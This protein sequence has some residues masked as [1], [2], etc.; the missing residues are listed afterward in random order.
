M[1]ITVNDPTSGFIN[2]CI[3]I[4]SSSAITLENLWISGTTNRGTYITDG[5][6]LTN[7]FRNGNGIG[8][9]GT[10]GTGGITVKYV[11]VRG[12]GRA[13]YTDSQG[14]YD[15]T[16]LLRYCTFAE[17]DGEF[18]IDDGVAVWSRAN[19]S[20]DTENHILIEKCIFANLPANGTAFGLGMRVDSF[21]NLDDLIRPILFSDGNLFWHC[22]VD[23][24]NWYQPDLQLEGF[25]TNDVS[26]D[27]QF[28][29]NSLV[30]PYSTEV[31][32]GWN[33]IPEPM[34]VSLVILL[35]IAYHLR[36][37]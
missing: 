14:G 8:V 30:L 16:N 12:F 25:A 10:I 20:S 35:W 15:N 21:D 22:G 24:E 28:L 17:Q 3:R 26:F 6:A 13:F 36:K 29:T 27:P 5:G 11:L 4:D 9:F 18:D 34:M 37:F 7:T 33:V 23:D 2:S 32:Y 19:A 31:D 1:H